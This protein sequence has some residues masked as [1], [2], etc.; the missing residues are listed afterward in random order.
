MTRSRVLLAGRLLLLG[1]CTASPVPI[2]PQLFPVSWTLPTA[3]WFQA[4]NT[5]AVTAHVN[6]L[7]AA[8]SASPVT[9]DPTLTTVAQTWAN[10]LG[11]TRTFGHSG[12]A[13][14]G[15]NLNVASLPK[16]HSDVHPPPGGGFA[17]TPAVL[18]SIDRWYAEM[19]AY[20]GSYSEATGHFTQLIWAE[21]R[22]IGIGFAVWG[23]ASQDQAIV[24]MNFYPP[25]NIMSAAAFHANVQ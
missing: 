17:S 9:I 20:N 24:V 1:M 2:A 13:A 18:A 12:F 7:R 11:G 6:A 22:S 10:Q 4:M 16:W 8:H 23:D 21:S 14:Y 3:G 5:T 19:H 15:E 25:G